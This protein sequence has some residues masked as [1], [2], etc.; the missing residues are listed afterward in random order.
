M[1]KTTSFFSIAIASF[2]FSFVVIHSADA[3]TIPISQLKSGDLIRG[4]SFSSVYYFGE[5]GFRYVFPND[6]IY[7]TWYAD[8]SKVKWISDTDMTKIQIGGNVTYRPGSKMIKINSDPNVYAISKNGTLRTIASET[9]AKEL[10]GTTWNKQIDD[11]PDGFFSNYK[12]GSV[13]EFPS[14]Y[15]IS[16]EKS[17]VTTINEDK[18]LKEASVVHISKDGYVDPTIYVKSG[19]AV[20]WIND[21]TK[22][23]TA[24]EWDGIWGTGTL[25]T[26]ETFTRYFLEKGTWMYYSKYDQPKTKMNGAIIVQ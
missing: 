16:S 1:K 23:H 25:K 26:G 18:S 9:V 14:Q 15:S 10:Y 20:R 17:D 2:L 24:S 19:T 22:D 6:K 11:L 13:I 7:F 21:D 5:D 12:K 3:A 8:F 4:A